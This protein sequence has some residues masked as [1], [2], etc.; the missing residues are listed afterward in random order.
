M[1]TGRQL[2]E[3]KP[4]DDRDTFDIAELAFSRQR[5][6]TS[7]HI[8]L[9]IPRTPGAYVSLSPQQRGV[10]IRQAKVTASRSLPFHPTNATFCSVVTMGDYFT[11][12]GRS[13]TTAGHASLMRNRSCRSHFCSRPATAF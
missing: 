6:S 13:H 8:C 1:A 3:F 11:S 2:R 7:L 5:V 4:P 9:R 10:S 12:R